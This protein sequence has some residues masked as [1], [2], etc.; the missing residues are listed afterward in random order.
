MKRMLFLV[1]SCAATAALWGCGPMQ[2]VMP[3]R[4]DG[5]G[6]EKVDEAWD[7]ALT[8]INHIDHSTML[9]A[10]LVSH[11]YQVG[12]DKLS[13]HSEKQVA[14]GTVVMDIQYDRKRPHDDR[15]EVRIYDATAQ[16]LR[17]ETYHRKEIEDANQDLFVRSK[18]LEQAEHAGNATPEELKKLQ[19]LKARMEAV[20]AIFPKDE[21]DAPKDEGKKP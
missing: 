5:D 11:A 18:Q 1:C 2:T 12:V 3:V 20:S 7:K 17:Q 8:P 10:F 15:F 4:L 16:L 14:A 21:H 9:D 13:F 6:Q 19:A